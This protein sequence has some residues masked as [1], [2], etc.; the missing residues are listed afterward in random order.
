MVFR[1]P[2]GRENLHLDRAVE[3]SVIHPAGDLWYVDDAL[4]H[5]PAVVEHIAHVGFPITNVIGKQPPSSTG[6]S[7]FGLKIGVPPAVKDIDGDA[8]HG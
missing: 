8:D 7:D 6:A 4:P 1:P 2:S 3:A 5:Q